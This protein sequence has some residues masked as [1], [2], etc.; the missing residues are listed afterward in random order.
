M[1]LCLRWGFSAALSLLA[2]RWTIDNPN[3]VL[4]PE[5]VLPDV[6]ANC[7]PMGG[8]GFVVAA[9]LAAG[10][11]TFDSTINKYVIS[12]HH[13][14]YSYFSVRRAIGPLIFTK[15]HG[16]HEPPSLR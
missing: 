4:D 2:I 8:K 15:E 10:M 13:H 11:T 14:S 1:L 12:L 5:Q 3:Y 9:I 6:L 16:I 7:L